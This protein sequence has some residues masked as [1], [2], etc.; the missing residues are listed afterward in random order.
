MGADEFSQFILAFM[1]QTGGGTTIVQQFQD[2]FLYG[3]VVAAQDGRAAGL[4][5]VDVAVIVDI[6]KIS[7]LRFIKSQ[8]EGIIKGQVVLDT[9]GNYIFCL[10][11]HC[12]GFGKILIKPAQVFIQ[13]FLFKW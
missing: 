7:T 1:K 3:G 4:E 6:P 10:S 9:A 2:F 12:L 11:N 5:K 8:R 13:S